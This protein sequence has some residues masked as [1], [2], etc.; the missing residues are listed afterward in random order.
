MII[1]LS[2][3][4][5]NSYVD[6]S[7]GEVVWHGIV[8]VVDVLYPIIGVDIVDAKLPHRPTHQRKSSDGVLTTV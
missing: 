8:V 7:A 1:R 2:E 3:L 5:Q 4:H 6:E